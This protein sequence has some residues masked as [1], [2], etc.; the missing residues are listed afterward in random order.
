MLKCK[1]RFPRS[2]KKI[3]MR[4]FEYYAPR[5]LKEALSLLENHREEARVL[6]GGTDLIVQMKDGRARPTVI[7]DVKK[8]PELNRLEWNDAKSLYI[9]ATVPL[10]KIITFPPVMEKFGILYQACSSIGSVQLRNRGTVGGNICNA[11]PSADSAPPLLCLGAQAMVARLGGSRTVPLD[12]FFRGPGQTALDHNELLLGLEIPA[13]P[14]LSSG[15]YL[16]HI[17]RQ[18]MDIAVVGVASFLVFDV[19][20]NRCREARIALGAVAP[21]PIRVPR[22]EAVLAGKVLTEKVIEE[23][24]EQAAEAA[25]PISDL[26]GSAEYRKEIVKVL[27]RR[28]LQRAWETYSI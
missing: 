9:G 7:V 12:S 28:T 15:C 11:A 23:A 17:P 27:T 26:R 8:L 2:P 10:S 25:R 22:A 1:N 18:D 3:T 5:S 13:L 19:Q 21:T 4:N 14:A 6:A 20:K 16:R 24:A